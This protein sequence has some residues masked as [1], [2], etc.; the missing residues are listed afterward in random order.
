MSADNRVKVFRSMHESGIFVVLNVWNAGTAKLAKHLGFSA[1]ATT[2]A[3]FAFS[4]GRVDEASA[5]AADDVFENVRA[6][7]AATDLPVTADLLNGFGHSP[8]DCATAIRR[9]AS[10]E[11]AGAS[12]E[13]ATGDDDS[14]IYDFGAAVARIEAAAEAAKETGL[15]LTARA[16]NHLYGV[17]DLRDTIARL[18][19][20]SEA[21]AEVLYAP[22]L[23][24]LEAIRAVCSEV[25]RPV[26]VV[27]GLREPTYSTE[28][29]LDAGVRRVSV[30]GALL[31]TVYGTIQR[32]A[33]QILD[34]G[35]FTFVEGAMPGAEITRVMRSHDGF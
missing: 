31:R 14:P 3:G 26:N 29:L 8:A 34:D 21:G 20:Y 7:T 25:D 13:D 15:V 33:R 1:L 16:E 9:A 30:G 2:S 32:A 17:S 27:M 4:S 6:I 35:T 24:D 23:P 22:G 19:A 18:Q 11:A 5:L 28:Q 12:I 10:V